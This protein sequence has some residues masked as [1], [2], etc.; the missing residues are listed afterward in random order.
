MHFNNHSLSAV[1]P[2]LSHFLSLKANFLQFSNMAKK[3]KTF[4]FQ[5]EKSGLLLKTPNWVTH[6]CC[7]KKYTD[8][9]LEVLKKSDYNTTSKKL[10]DPKFKNMKEMTGCPDLEKSE[11]TT[12]HYATQPEMF[13][14][15]KKTC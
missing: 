9:G 2:A 13:C 10:K 5:K 14:V 6:Y 8:M 15:V 7:I 3:K 4:T 12:Q 11:A 1:R